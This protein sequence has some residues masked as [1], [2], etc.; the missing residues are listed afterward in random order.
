MS[1]CTTTCYTTSCFSSSRASTR[2]ISL[3]LTLQWASFLLPLHCLPQRKLSALVEAREASGPAA[4]QL[5][6]DRSAG[7]PWRSMNMMSRMFCI[8]NTASW[9]K[10]S[11]VSSN[12]MTKYITD[13]C[14]HN[15]F[16]RLKWYLL[17]ATKLNIIEDNVRRKQNPIF[18]YY[19][20]FALPFLPHCINA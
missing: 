19:K 11:V 3:S 15:P 18:T 6:G 8:H 1:F 9:F 2:A 5:E 20:Y 7:Y 17:L 4:S 16:Y 14:F 13:S 10:V 12:H